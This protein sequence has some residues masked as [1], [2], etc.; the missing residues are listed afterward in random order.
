MKQTGLKPH[1]SSRRGWGPTQAAAPALFA[2][3]PSSL[4][5]ASSQLQGSRHIQAA[6]GQVDTPPPEPAELRNAG[7]RLTGSCASRNR[8]AKSVLHP[9]RERICGAA[10]ASLL[11]ICISCA[12][13]MCAAAAL[14]SSAQTSPTFP[15]FPPSPHTPKQ[16]SALA[17][18]PHL[19]AVALPVSADDELAL[20]VAAR[21]VRLN[22]VLDQAALVGA[23]HLLGR[24]GQTCKQ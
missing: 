6:L 12:S 4:F 3:A 20:G 8:P 22:P 13:E 17:G 23:A 1:T 21:L 10:Q 15:P 11:T 19:R 7:Q 2:K 5:Q 24:V 9:T 14:E 18:C 16:T